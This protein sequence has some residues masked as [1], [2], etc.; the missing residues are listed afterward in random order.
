[1]GNTGT[2]LRGKTS[3]SPFPRINLCCLYERG[4]ITSID[5]LLK[6][7]FVFSRNLLRELVI[8]KVS[9]LEI[10][11]HVAT[12]F[13]QRFL[14]YDYYINTRYDGTCNAIKSI[15]NSSKVKR[16]SSIS[17]KKLSLRIFLKFNTSDV[18]V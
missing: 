7:Q 3:F 15:F 2:R 17:E 8:F 6:M 13:F 16:R 1:M 9:H 14:L 11:G 12:F 10:S 18:A 5:M 4:T